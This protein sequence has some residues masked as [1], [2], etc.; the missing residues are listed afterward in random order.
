[1]VVGRDAAAQQPPR[2]GQALEQ[3]HLGAAGAAQQLAGGE[4]AGRPGADDRDPRRGAHE[5]GVRSAK[6][7]ALRSSAYS[8]FSGVSWSA[9]IASTGQTST[10]ASQSMQVS[11]SM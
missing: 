4:R 8:Y 5:T 11:G 3:V 2:G 9:K 1:M 7:W 10:Q 6:N